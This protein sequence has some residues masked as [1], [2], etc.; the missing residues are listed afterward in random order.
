MSHQLHSSITNTNSP[1][2]VPH[3]V[4]ASLVSLQ[5]KNRFLMTLRLY[6]KPDMLSHYVCLLCQH[7]RYCMS[8]KDA[9]KTSIR[10]C[11]RLHRSPFF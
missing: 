10:G 8:T 2:R 7:L 1:N 9:L 6:S 5:V 4:E 3:A 11:G